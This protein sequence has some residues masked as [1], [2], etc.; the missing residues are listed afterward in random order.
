MTSDDDAPPVPGDAPTRPRAGWVARRT[1]VLATRRTV[2]IGIVAVLAIG[3]AGAWW[4]A[5][6]PDRQGV[7]RV[8]GEPDCPGFVAPTPQQRDGLAENLVPIMP[9][10]PVGPDG[11]TVCRYPGMNSRTD[12]VIHGA[13]LDAA[14]TAEVAGWLDTERDPAQSPDACLGQDDGSRIVLT[15]R[16]PQGPPVQVTIRTS[17]CPATTNGVRREVT[18]H[19]VVARIERLVPSS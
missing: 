9:E 5:G 19:D 7:A 14:R 12:G 10:F 6:G 8:S 18:P 11:A 13:I 3:A 4:L 1:G 15:F 16:Y 2:T 17:G